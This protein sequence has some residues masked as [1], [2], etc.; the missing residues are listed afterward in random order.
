VQESENGYA[1]TG[2][3]FGRDGLVLEQKQLHRVARHAAWQQTLGDG[4]LTV[5]L[6]FGR[7]ALIIGEDSIYPEVFR[8]AALQ[9]VEIAL[10]PTRIAEAWELTTGLLERAAENRLNVLV[11]SR[12]TPA[13]AS[14]ILTIDEDFTLWTP[15]KNRPFDGNINYPIVTRMTEETGLLCGDVHPAR[16]ANRLVSQKTDVV[17]GRPWWLLDALVNEL[18]PVSEKGLV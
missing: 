7:A 2:V 9:N 3:L 1:H 12:A 18:S 14:A 6:P 17:D 16:S 15:W 5:D 10:V 4:L 8:L 11:A 13:G